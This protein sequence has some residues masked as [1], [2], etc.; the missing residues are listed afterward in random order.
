MTVSTDNRKAGPFTGNGTTTAFPFTFF[1]FD[2]SD[3]VV[4]RTDSSGVETT[5][6]L[7]TDYTISVNSD[8]SS[9]PG[10][11]V[12]L[13]TA[14][15]T[16][17]TLTLTTELSNTQ[18][19]DFTNQGGFY[20]SV[21]N[22]ALDREVVL[23]QQLSEKVSR[24]LK[25]AVST[26]D[27]VSGD[28]PKPV[29]GRLLG[30]NDAGTAII[31]Q[32][33]T[34]GGA[35]ALKQTLQAGDASM[36]GYLFGS[37]ANQS[38]LHDRLKY[39]VNIVT[40]YGADNTGTTSATAAIQSAVNSGA[41]VVCCPAGQ[42]KMTGKVTVPANV[43]IIGEGWSGIQTQSPTYGTIFVC[44]FLPTVA[45][46][47]FYTESP[48]C[49]FQDFEIFCNYQ[50]AAVSG[51][52][53]ISTPTGIHVY[54]APYNNTGGAEDTIVRNVMFRAMTRGVY[55]EGADRGEFSLYGQTFGPLLQ[56]DGSFDTAKVHLLHGWS[57]YSSDPNVLS[58]TR[59]NADIALVGRAD[60]TQW[61]NIFGFGVRSGIYYVTSSRQ[62]G[63]GSQ[64]HKILNLCVDDCY[65]GIL[66][67]NASQVTAEVAN[68]RAYC[69]SSA[70]ASTAPS[71][72]IFD[73]GGTGQLLL[74]IGSLS[75][76]GA[77]GEAIHTDIATSVISIANLNVDS[78]NQFN[79]NFFA[80]SCASGSVINIGNKRIDT[81]QG[82]GMGEFN[83]LTGGQYNWNGPRAFTVTNPGV[84][85]FYAKVD[86]APRLHKRY[87]G[88]KAVTISA[89]GFTN[90][91]ETFCDSGTLSKVLYARAS[92]A[93]LV[94]GALAVDIYD[95]TQWASI[96]SKVSASGTIYSSATGTVYIDYEV[97]GYV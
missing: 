88:R 40:D 1:V 25:L 48:R 30:W 87:F 37:G 77:G 74:N 62:E 23:I 43:I 13:K 27:G 83:S 90:W 82:N 14:L 71:R 70:G 85:T 45:A 20:P 68:M 56:I 21:L 96:G 12:T 3:V 6:T 5:L 59:T 54:R 75:V 19:V 49:V 53:P 55:I 36:L 61:G 32:D 42:Y 38:S 69:N 2:K 76:Q 58:W 64:S 94:N 50:P 15:A 93:S 17:Y 18:E 78:Y 4:V 92:L 91:S 97:V 44:T 63:G 95:G 89:S 34:Y 80:L 60:N 73:T 24:T 8:Q 33:P 31:N 84:E 86:G 65:Y 52:A 72:G 7:T 81:T 51:W 16:G 10:G 67:N 47:V 35:D 41:K 9:S 22:K 26:P 79:N 29:S 66:K 46:D 39:L 28:L 57:F 11:T